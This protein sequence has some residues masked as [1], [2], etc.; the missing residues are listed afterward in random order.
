MI[1]KI[2]TKSV[3]FDIDPKNVQGSLQTILNELIQVRLR[4][5]RILIT[6]NFKDR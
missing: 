4:A 1:K 2:K 5:E 3:K 6:L